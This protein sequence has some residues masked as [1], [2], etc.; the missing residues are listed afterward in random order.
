MSKRAKILTANDVK[1]AE[2]VAAVAREKWQTMRN[3]LDEQ[4]AGPKRRQ[5]IGRCFKYRNCYSCPEKPSDYWWLWFRATGT[6]GWM[7]TGPKIQ[8]DSNG[9]I[10]IERYAAIAVDGTLDPKYVQVSRREYD[11]ETRKILALARQEALT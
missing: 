1:R 11:R 9:K 10:D 2:H 3:E 4:E 5:L 8:C 7:V 6:S